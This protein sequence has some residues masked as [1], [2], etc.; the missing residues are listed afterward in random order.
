MDVVFLFL[1]YKN[2]ELV[3]HTCKELEDEDVYFYFHVDCNSKENFDCL[4]KI[5]NSFF[6]KKR[7]PVS[8]A[9]PNLV[10][11]TFD[12]FKEIIRNH[13]QGH[14]ILMSESD[15]PVKRINYIKQ[16]LKKNKKDYIVTHERKHPTPF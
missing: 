11:A 7:Y 4:K 14:V 12:Y 13:S 3:Y 5:R 15:Y 6:P 8:W 16:Y 1:I 2:A 9:S 10:F